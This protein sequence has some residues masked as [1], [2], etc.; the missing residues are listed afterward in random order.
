MVPFEVFL[1]FSQKDLAPNTFGRMC[2]TYL[3]FVWKP[4]NKEVFFLLSFWTVTVCFYFFSLF[5]KNFIKHFFVE[6]TFGTIL[7]IIWEVT[8]GLPLV[9]DPDWI[10]LVFFL[11]CGLCMFIS[12]PYLANLRSEKLIFFLRC[13]LA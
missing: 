2:L 1:A 8:E 6:E 7:I 4:I 12:F 5:L 13:A 10:F 9:A 11:L 3:C